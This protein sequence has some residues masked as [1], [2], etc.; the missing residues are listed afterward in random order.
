MRQVVRFFALAAI[1]A[2]PGA[3]FGAGGEDVDSATPSSN[4]AFTYDLYAAGI[5][6]GQVTLSAR[7]DGNSYKATSTLETQGVV[8]VLWKARIDASSSGTIGNSVHPT[9]YFANS[10][11]NDA[12]QQV[13][14][15]YKPGEAPSYFAQPRYT[16]ESKLGM[17][18][19]LKKQGLDPV[20]AMLSFVLSAD[21]DKAKPCGEM[22]PVYDARRRYDV[23]LSFVR[24]ANVSMDNGLYKGPVEVCKIAYRPLAGPKQRVLENGNI[25]NLF[26]WLTSLSSPSDPAHHYLVP[27]RIWVE[28]DLGM[29]VAV[30]SKITL[31]GKT[32][33]PAG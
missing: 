11:H 26:V 32:I 2:V 22:L 21:A 3:S 14:L 5:P 13:T 7:F 20:S 12:D 6:L 15:T 27:L 18:D 30:A 29:G 8:N 31:D 16:D 23:N 28:T 19:E 25:P 24:N 1:V 9:L 17:P 33:G 10:R 4:L